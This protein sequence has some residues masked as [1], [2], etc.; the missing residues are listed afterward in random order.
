[1]PLTRTKP[2]IANLF[3][4]GFAVLMTATFVAAQDNGTHSPPVNTEKSC[5]L[6]VQRFYDW[7][8]PMASKEDVW[9]A[10]DVAVKKRPE[11]FTAELARLIRQDTEAQREAS[12]LVSLDFDPFLN[13]QDPSDRFTVQNA[14]LKGTGCWVEVRGI[15]NGVKRETVTPE[16]KCIHGHC[17]FVNFHYSEGPRR[18]I[19]LLSLLK[20]DH[21]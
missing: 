7:Y 3:F 10:W 2:A 16:V 4:V 20:S 9:R 1:M 6:F 12:D 13:S 17:R 14:K 8:V 19:D 15:S 21:R 5:R 11:A 18:P